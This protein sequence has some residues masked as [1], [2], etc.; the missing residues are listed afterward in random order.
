MKISQ[1]DELK[2]N[3]T[4]KPHQESAKPC[5]LLALVWFIFLLWLVPQPSLLLSDCS[6]VMLIGVFIRIDSSM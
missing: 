1:E 6:L 3:M 5:L 4:H 2:K